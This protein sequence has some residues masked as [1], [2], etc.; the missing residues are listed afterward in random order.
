[1][2][3]W[4]VLPPV[5]QVFT[6]YLDDVVGAHRDDDR[7]CLWDPCNESLMGRYVDDPASPIRAA[8]LRWLSWCRDVCR[9]AEATNPSWLATTRT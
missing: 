1:M 2:Q 4:V 6:S 9:G 8:E 3:L 7:I 5:E